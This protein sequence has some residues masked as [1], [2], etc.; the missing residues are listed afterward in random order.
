MAMH[1]VASKTY[2]KALDPTSTVPT[3]DTTNHAH[4]PPILGVRT[5][6]LQNLPFVHVNAKES[7]YR[8]VY[9]MWEYLSS[10]NK[11]ILVFETHNICKVWTLTLELKSKICTLRTALQFQSEVQQLRRSHTHAYNTLCIRNLHLHT[12]LC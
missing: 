1:W 5:E 4:S 9:K 11:S 2:L 12:S 3:E 10:N 8:L 7:E 6:M